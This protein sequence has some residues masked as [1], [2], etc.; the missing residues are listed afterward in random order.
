MVFGGI[1][2]VKHFGSSFVHNFLSG[3]FC[4]VWQIKRAIVFPQKYTNGEEIGQEMTNVMAI[5]V[6]KDFA[7]FFSGMRKSH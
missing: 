6:M 5:F 3:M 4:L 7:F 1:L 2:L